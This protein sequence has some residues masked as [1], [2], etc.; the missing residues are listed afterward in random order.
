MRACADVVFQQDDVHYH[1]VERSEGYFRRSLALPEGVD[2]K[3]ITC[4]FENG[5]LTVRIPKPVDTRRV[6]E[7]IL[8]VLPP[9]I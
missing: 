8:E 6:D 5:V 3:R 1:R 9:I 2:T 4:T 7:Q